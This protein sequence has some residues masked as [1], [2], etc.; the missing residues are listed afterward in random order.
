MSS[1]S[2]CKK[3][4]LTLNLLPEQKAKQLNYHGTAVLGQNQYVSA[5]IHV[6]INDLL[7]G[8]S[9]EQIGKVV[10]DIAQRCRN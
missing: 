9:I 1:I 7:N 4:K 6:G 3:E 2:F 10:I 8:S 5:I